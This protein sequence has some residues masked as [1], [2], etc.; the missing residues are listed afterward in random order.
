MREEAR[1]LASATPL[2]DDDRVER[3]LNFFGVSFRRTSAEELAA[4]LSGGPSDAPRRVLCSAAAFESF[5]AT[6]A[7]APGL[8]EQ[9]QKGLHSVF[10][11][12]G[13]DD[14]AVGRVTRSLGSE[15]ASPLIEN[16]GLSQ[17]TISKDADG[18]S[19][20]LGGLEIA[21]SPSAAPPK[22]VFDTSA[23][24]GAGLISAGG[25]AALTKIKWGSAAVYVSLAEVIDIDAELT[26]PN[27]DVRD[28]FLSAVP[29]V[30]YLRS[31]FPN[32]AWHAAES[33]ACLIIDD[34]LLRRRYGFIR[35]QELLRSMERH[36]FTTNVA[37]IPWNWRR[38]NS[39]TVRL[40]AENPAHYSVSI[41]GCDHTAAEFGTS[42][43]RK[44]R[45]M[46]ATA[47]ERM[48][49]HTTRTG[50]RHEQIM[51]FPQG[52]FSVEAIRELKRANFSAIVN[53]EV[54]PTGGNGSGVTIRDVWDVAVMKYADFPIYT[55]RYPKQGV[56][57]QAFDLLLGKPCC[58]VIHHDFCSDGGA[59]LLEFVQRL[60]ALEGGLTWR[61]PGEVVKR[62][63]RQRKL[64]SGV[65]EVEMYGSELLL[66][67][68]S[69]KVKHF[70]IRRRERDPS[71]VEQLVAGD[72]TI[73]WSASDGFLQCELALQPGESK[74][75]RICFRAATREQKSRAHLRAMLKV[76][77]RRHLSEFRDNYVVPAKSLLRG[78]AN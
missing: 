77:L 11:Y 16:S 75:L 25:C 59:R 36:N 37:F 63:Y 52:V 30:M 22:N 35:F 3:L 38:N 74:T 33:G 2:P 76:R 45:E 47:T 61:S 64:P 13:A 28:H 43:A 27:F 39:R 20:V 49:Q 31:A 14:L 70:R 40:F 29:I 21:T 60:N 7:D 55:R 71:S 53:T 44:L 41:H 50:L 46:V 57:N 26:T 48:F 69:A 15:T 58:I 73:S 54:S 23:A 1:L 4:E 56:E 42:D 51:V 62:S 66:E 34:P 78:G 65:T 18:F 6:I 68:A 10:I 17:W 12:S 72:E 8:L 9:C 24:P 32:S 19:G 67:N 5:L